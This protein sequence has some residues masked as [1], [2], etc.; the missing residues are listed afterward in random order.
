MEG[1]LEPSVIV[2]PGSSGVPCMHIVCIGLQITQASQ[3]EGI[4][5]EKKE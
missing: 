4:C 5:N 3:M 2:L 1:L